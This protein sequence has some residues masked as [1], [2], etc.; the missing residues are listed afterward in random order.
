MIYINET[1]YEGYH[2][3]LFDSNNNLYVNNI[4]SS[5]VINLIQYI[6]AVVL[7]KNQKL[8][9]SKGIKVQLVLVM[10]T[11]LI[12]ILMVISKI[13]FNINFT[14]VFILLFILF[15]YINSNVHKLYLKKQDEKIYKEI[16]KEKKWIKG[17]I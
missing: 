16:E 8:L 17:K 11:I 3:S 4:I 10:A 7:N 14:I 2:Q 6:A 9:N 12:P 13:E 15:Y 5:N 1:N